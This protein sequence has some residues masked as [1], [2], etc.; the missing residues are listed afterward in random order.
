MATEATPRTLEAAEEQVLE[1]IRKLAAEVGGGRAAR[2]VAPRASLDRD[3]GL[4]SLEK[5]E[6]LLRLEAAF[7]QTFD[8]RYL[9]LDTPREFARLLVEGQS[10]S[11]PAPAAPAGA[12]PLEPA[13]PAAHVTTI[14]GS[15]WSR[16]DENPLR[17]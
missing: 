2:A 10:V 12:A 1:V 14:H 13:T 17:P 4:G 8:D 16:A 15:L 5:V 7:G 11:E 6:L 3:V 9:A